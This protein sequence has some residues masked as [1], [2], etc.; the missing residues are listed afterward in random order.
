MRI[1][2]LRAFHNVATHGSFT[3]AAKAMRVSQPTLTGQVRELEETY[4]VQLFIRQGRK[5]F[6]TEEGKGLQPIATRLFA[7]EIDAI[8]YLR[9]TKELRVGHLRIAAVG[10][11]TVT[12]FLRLF[13]ARYPEVSVAVSNANSQGA[14]ESLRDYQ[15]EVAVLYQ[16]DDDPTLETIVLQSQR[17]L[18]LVHKD[19]RFFGKKS[20]RLQ[21]LEG[22]SLIRREHG[23]MTRELLDGALAAVGI[24]PKAIL[25]IGTREAVREAVAS[26]LGISAIL[27]EQHLPSE[28]L[29][30]LPIR[31]ADIK[32]NTHVSV[33]KERRHSRLVLSFMAV[34]RE[35][36]EAKLSL[37]GGRALR[38]DKK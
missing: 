14:L 15:A 36:A 24:K 28:N 20:V 7:N 32:S 30:A 3:E 9:D 19:H 18:I 37:D 23:S 6:L 35:I 34:V 25:E 21:D 16:K 1:T 8:D 17:L 29:W 26:G 11:S 33:L 13:H 4:G 27:E 38:T 10:P 31:D 22:E 12:D 5:V 2:Q